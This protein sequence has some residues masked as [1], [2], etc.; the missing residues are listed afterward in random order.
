MSAVERRRTALVT[1]NSAPPR[2]RPSS[3]AELSALVGTQGVDPDRIDL[4]AI[5]PRDF[6]RY[7]TRPGTWRRRQTKQQR[8]EAI[9]VGIESLE[10]TIE[11]V[12]WERPDLVAKVDELRG[13]LEAAREGEDDAAYLL[14]SFLR[15]EVARAENNVDASRTSERNLRL[16]IEGQRRALKEL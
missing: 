3:V 8:R 6:D 9:V 14:R 16:E 2:P 13:R 12:K 7:L 10:D 5:D 1:P 15:V 4:G 11:R